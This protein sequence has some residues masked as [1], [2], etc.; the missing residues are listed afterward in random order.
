MGRKAL[1]PKEKKFRDIES[2]MKD[3]QLKA[4]LS[5]LIDE[6]VTCKGAIA[7]QQETIKALRDEAVSSIQ[8]SP[9]LFNAY[10]SA[11][12]NNDYQ[13]RRQSLEEQVTLLEY[14]MGDSGVLTSRDD[15]DE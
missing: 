9:K 15:D 8:I 1:S 13:L 11:A 12:F 7:V 2:I 10:V 5:N 4:V 14:I 6:A 3:P